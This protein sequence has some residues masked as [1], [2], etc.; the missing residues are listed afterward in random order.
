MIKTGLQKSQKYPGMFAYLQ[1]QKLGIIFFP[2]MT[3]TQTAKNPHFSILLMC[4]AMYA[5]LFR[6]VNA[7]LLRIWTQHIIPLAHWSARALSFNTQ[8]SASSS[9]LL[10][11]V[12]ITFFPEKKKKKNFFHHWTGDKK[13]AK[14]P[15]CKAACFQNIKKK[16]W[17]FFF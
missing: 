6:H 9:K 3:K 4:L 5:E 2:F 11:E 14:L 7:S 12:K 1:Y 13:G 15:I 17:L 8:D 10:Y 16:F